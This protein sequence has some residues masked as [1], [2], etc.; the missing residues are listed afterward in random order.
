MTG[1]GRRR[2]GAD[3]KAPRRP[4]QSEIGKR[5][6]RQCGSA[7]EAGAVRR[8]GVKS[9]RTV[10]YSAAGRRIFL[11][12]AEP[13]RAERSAGTTRDRPARPAE[14]VLSRAAGGLP[15]AA[16]FAAG[17]HTEC[18]CPVHGGR[19]VGSRS[20]GGRVIGRAAGRNRHRPRDCLSRHAED[21]GSRRTAPWAIATEKTTSQRQG[22]RQAGDSPASHPPPARIGER[23]R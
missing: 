16:L 13:R 15:S 20:S 7:G 21:R 8:L 9:R 22:Q 12:P 3:D 1:P 2:R 14:R 17:W 10:N 6:H 23:R 4:R 18:H 19:S 5:G 11:I